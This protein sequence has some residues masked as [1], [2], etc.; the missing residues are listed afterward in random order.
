MRWR[1]PREL[2]T[3][4]CTDLDGEDSSDLILVLHWFE[5]LKEPARY[6]SSPYCKPRNVCLWCGVAPSRST[7]S[8]CS[9]V[10]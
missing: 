8:R 10:P 9:V 1:T 3:Q 7:A 6:S 2:E 5:G 4:G